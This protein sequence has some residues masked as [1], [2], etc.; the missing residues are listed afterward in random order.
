M[1]IKVEENTGTNGQGLKCKQ[2]ISLAFCHLVLDRGHVL[3]L[4]TVVPF[5]FSLKYHSMN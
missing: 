1:D 4:P 3:V 2:W 5:T